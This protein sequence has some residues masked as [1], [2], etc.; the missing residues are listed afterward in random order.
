MQELTDKREQPVRART[1]A[2]RTPRRAVAVDAAL[3]S[4]NL[5]RLKRIEG[6]VRGVQRM[7]EE[8]RYC[9]DVMIQ[10]AAINEALRAVARELLHNHLR[11]CATEAIRSGSS[12]R[13]EEMYSE[14][15]DLF[16]KFAR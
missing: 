3:K 16:G 6:Q 10:I 13:A 5:R 14:L 11:H 7:V 4:R 9:A 15:S 1:A 12:K 2:A 8:G